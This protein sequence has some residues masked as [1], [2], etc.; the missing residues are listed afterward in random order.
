MCVC[1]CVC[2]LCALCACVC[3]CVWCVCIGDRP[4]ILKKFPIILLLDSPEFILLFLYSYPII[5]VLLSYYSYDYS[6]SKRRIQITSY[7]VQDSS[8]ALALTSIVTYC[9]PCTVYCVPCTVYRVPCTV[10][11]VL[12]TVY[13]VPCTV[14]RVPCTVPRG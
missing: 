1:V 3:V 2:V 7:Y 8:S 5:P 12:C 14:Y 10:Y 9:V 11:C 4:I 6:T 13:R